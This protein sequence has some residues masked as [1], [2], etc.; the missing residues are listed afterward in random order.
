M[1]WRTIRIALLIM[2]TGL[3]VACGEAITPEE[4][5]EPS[6]TTKESQVSSDDGFVYVIISAKG[7]WTIDLQ[8]PST[9][10]SD[11]ATMDPA[12]GED[13]PPAARLRFS[14]NE[15]EES[16]TVTLVLNNRGKQ[17]SATVEQLGQSEPELPPS[18]PPGPGVTYG[19]GYDV[20]NIE[21]LELPETKA[22]DGCE[23]L[24]HDMEGNKY[25]SQAKS[26]VRNWSCYWS[27]DEH[28]SFWVA[29]PHNSAL[30]GKGSR[31]DA[32]G[33][34]DP[35]I[36]SSLQPNMAYTY[37]GGW[38]RGHQIASADRYISQANRSTFYPTNMTPQDYDFNA[39]IWAN[40]ENQ[41]RSYASTSDT[42]YV[43]TGCVLD[44]SYT[45]S[46]S[47]SGFTVKVP[48]A[49]FKAALQ[50]STSSSVGYSGWRAAAWYMP[51]DSGIASGNYKSYVMTVDALEAKLG[52]DLFVNLPSKVGKTL[53]DQIEADCNWAK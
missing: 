23:L 31:S 49:Y 15:A 10:P 30:I 46:G 16:R 25:I 1:F 22:G 41:I 18:P 51:H 6:I 52:Y 39:K 17:V 53:A 47:N 35:I 7:A 26:G 27:Y 34:F 8:Y 45:Y 12:S 3:A 4:P 28:V 44:G 13:V 50:K 29:Y 21:W 14:Q 38:T 42:L 37:G 5:F 19:Y 32:W 33:V 43:V 9:G 48:A 40:L 20:C 11:W 36:P 24:V 2:V